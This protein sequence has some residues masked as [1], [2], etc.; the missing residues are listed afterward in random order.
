MEKRGW[1]AWFEDW[2]MG[3]LVEIFERRTRQYFATQ[4]K[5]GVEIKIKPFTEAEI[6]GFV[7]DYERRWD[8]T[9]IWV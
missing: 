9:T 7:D 6:T 5:K 8:G 4:K 3:L 2:E 1:Q